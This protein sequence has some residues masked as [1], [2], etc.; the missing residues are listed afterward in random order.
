[1]GGGLQ[2]ICSEFI[3]SS[4]ILLLF[5]DFQAYQIYPNTIGTM[6]ETYIIVVRVNLLDDAFSIVRELLRSEDEG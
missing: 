6:N 4:V 5:I 2:Y 1:M 3:S